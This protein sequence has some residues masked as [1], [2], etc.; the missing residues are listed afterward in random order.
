M[1]YGVT[2]PAV[3]NNNKKKSG[4][5]WPMST[6]ELWVSLFRVTMQKKNFFEKKKYFIVLGSLL[7]F[8]LLPIKKNIPIKEDQSL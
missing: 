5:A 8:C 6:P 1:N 3:K 2:L 4:L 7:V